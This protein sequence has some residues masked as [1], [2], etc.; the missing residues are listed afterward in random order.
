MVPN[1]SSSAGS[2]GEKLSIAAVSVGVVNGV[3]LLDLPYTED[4][5]AEVDANIVMTGQGQFVEV[6]SSGEEAT[7]AARNSPICSIWEERELNSC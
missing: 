5:D 6:Q 3:A 2:V 4:R 7:S 1:A